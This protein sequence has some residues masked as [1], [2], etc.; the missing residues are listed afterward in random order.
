MIKSV[1]H[2]NIY[3]MKQHRAKFRLFLLSLL[4][5]ISLNACNRNHQNNKDTDT[6]IASD[7]AFSEAIYNDA[8]NMADE[9][10]NLQTGDNLSNYKTASN[11]ATITHDTTT[12]PKTITIDFG[13]TY[14]LCNDGKYRKGI[15][16]I[17]YTGHY[18]DSGSVRTI[19]FNQYFV[20]NHQVLG[21]KTVS[22][23]GYNTNGQTFFNIVVNGL[24]IK[25]TG[26][27][28]SW[29]QNRVRTWIA[30]E[31]TSAK[32]DDV[33]EITGSGSGTRANG[34]TYTVTITQPLVRALACQWIQS[35]EIS[36][37]PVGGNTRVLNF[38]NGTCDDQATVSINGTTY[39]ITLN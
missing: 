21:S 29:N 31:N 30:G 22:N 37:Q 7:N 11:C 39:T 26:D 38:G 27:S 32:I 25:S 35:G 2:K 18:K 1:W 5:L 16:L 15:V 34:N 17:S 9:A 14:C 8:L 20:N 13:N 24:I 6:S 10:S 33:Y 36:I 3:N 12:N 23:M 19:T 4:W 28:V